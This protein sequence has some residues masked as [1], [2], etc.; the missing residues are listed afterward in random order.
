MI[1][2]TGAT[3]TRLG[4]AA[5]CANAT[6]I[7]MYVTHE[8]VTPTQEPVRSASTM[9]L[10]PIVR[11]AQTG[12]LVMLFVARIAEVRILNRRNGKCS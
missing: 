9:L 3:R 6:I 2:V 12:T 8:V 10:V 1:L 4:G 7:S 11:D 5:E